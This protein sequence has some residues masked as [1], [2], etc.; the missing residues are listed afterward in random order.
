L[1]CIA[2][3]CVV[4]VLT[5]VSEGLLFAFALTVLFLGGALAAGYY[6]FENLS[7]TVLALI[8]MKLNL[9]KSVFWSIFLQPQ[10]LIWQSPDFLRIKSR[11]FKYSK[12]ISVFYY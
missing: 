1:K 8:M 12:A 2:I 3:P 4:E 6:S 5:E 7:T 9:V 10:S 11:N